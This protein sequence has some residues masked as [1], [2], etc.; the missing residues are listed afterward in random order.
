MTKDQQLNSN[1]MKSSDCRTNTNRSRRT[2]HCRTNVAHI[3]S[4]YDQT[5][6][7]LLFRAVNSCEQ[8]NQG[9]NPYINKENKL[10]LI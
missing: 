2:G 7:T 4:L 6:L 1:S 10:K 3:N 5:S 9:K 8:V